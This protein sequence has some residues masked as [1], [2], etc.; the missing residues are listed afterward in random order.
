MS[1]HWIRLPRHKWPKSWSSME[2]PVVPLERNLYG[3]SLAGLLWERQF[4]NIL[5]KYCWEKVPNWDCLF[6]HREKGLF[7]SVYVDD[8]KLAGKWQNINPMWKILKKEVD[9]GEPTSFLYHVYL[10]CTQ[11]QCEISKDIV[12]EQLKN[13]HDRKIFES[14]CGPVTWRV[15]PKTIGTILWVSKQDD[16]TTLQSIFSMQWW[17]SFPRRRLEIRGRM[18]KHMLSNCS[19][20]LTLGT[21]WTTRYSM[22]SEQTCTIDYELDQSLWQTIESIWSLTSITHVDTNNIFMWET[23]QNNADWDCFR[24]YFAKDLEVSKSTSGGLLCIFGSSETNL[25]DRSRTNF[26]SWTRI[27]GMYSMW[28]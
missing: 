21:H 13:F 28:M 11:R 5:L 26:I 2:D 6:V 25:H 16:S 15:M 10:G 3:H 12:D 14:L 19:E 1:R 18:V 22:V 7:L 24:T 20:M 17:P 23:L 27:F 4:E 9:L 8:M